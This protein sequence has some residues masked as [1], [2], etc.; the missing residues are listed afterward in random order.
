M[1]ARI[2]ELLTR[3]NHVKGVKAKEA[4][5]K[6]CS[7]LICRLKSTREDLDPQSIWNRINR[8][9]GVLVN[10]G[11]HSYWFRQ[12]MKT[13]VIEAHCDLKALERDRLLE[14][15]IALNE[16]QRKILLLLGTDDLLGQDD[17]PEGLALDYIK[18]LIDLRKQ[19]LAEYPEVNGWR[20]KLRSAATR[21][22]RLA[23]L[24]S[25]VRSIGDETQKV[26]KELE[27]RG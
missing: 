5:R 1:A 23:V 7:E 9:L 6:E 12:P 26:V 20:D 14:R 24:C 13:E 10:A 25:K 21:K 4:C 19:I 16:E 11:D 3:E 22:E 15:M 2:A 17:P 18:K 27:G 8:N